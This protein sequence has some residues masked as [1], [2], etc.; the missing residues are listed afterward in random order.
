MSKTITLRNPDGTC[1]VTYRLV[2]AHGDPLAGFLLPTVVI[3]SPA[4]GRDALAAIMAMARY[5]RVEI[6]EPDGRWS[7]VDTCSRS[8][9]FSVLRPVT[10]LSDFGDDVP[11]YCKTI[12][13]T[14]VAR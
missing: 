13:G 7:K 3:T 8:A 14:G 2:N 4:V 6:L 9:A 1:S 10:G 12:C 5:T 11:D